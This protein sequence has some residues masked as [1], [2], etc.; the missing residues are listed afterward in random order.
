MRKLFA[1]IRA[2]AK[3]E[4]VRAEGNI[5]Y[6]YD[7]I[8]SSKADAEWLGGCDAETFV[9]SLAAMTGDVTVRVNSPGGDVFAGVAMST[10][11]RNYPGKVTCVV[12]GYAASA[13]SV[14]AI[15]GDTVAMAPGALMMIHDAWTIAMGGAEEFM[16]TAALLEKID[17][18]LAAGY[19]A[20][21]AKRMT[22]GPDAAAFAALMDDE[23][24]LTAEE[25]I[26]TG[27]ADAIVEAPAK[28]SAAW[29]LSVYAK[30]PKVE[31]DAPIDVVPLPEPVNDNTEIEARQ[32]KVAVALL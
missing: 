27:L 31:A 13:A 19:A 28:V 1:L 11:I 5:L 20:A 10:A 12:D 17:G 9:Q 32:R 29:D 3:R 26:A 25:A 7:I 14:L 23:T 18:T 30:A 4:P 21:S 24:W 15:A 8:V 22:G 16:S 2:N 6:V